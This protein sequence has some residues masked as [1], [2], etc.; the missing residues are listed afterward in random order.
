MIALLHWVILW[1]SYNNIFYLRLLYW[2]IKDCKI[3]D[4]DL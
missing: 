3:E 1:P 4:F 2:L